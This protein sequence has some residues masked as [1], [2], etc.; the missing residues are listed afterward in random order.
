MPRFSLR[1]L[2]GH[3]RPYCFRLNDEQMDCRF[4]ESVAG[5]AEEKRQTSCR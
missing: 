3:Q 5:Y 1:P 4:D 2:I